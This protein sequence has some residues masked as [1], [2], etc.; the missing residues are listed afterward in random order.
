MKNKLT[1]LVTSLL[2]L[3]VLPVIMAAGIGEGIG[4]DIEVEPFKPIVW[5]C[6]HRYMQDDE[7][8]PWRFTNDDEFLYERAGNYLF[9]GEKFTVDVVVFDK[10]KIQDVV[11]DL[12][13]GESAGDMDYNVNCVERDNS[14]RDFYKC[15]A[16]I[17]EE[18]INEFDSAT[19]RGFTC[20]FTALDSEHMYGFHWLTVQADD[21]DDVGVYDEMTPLYLNPMI[22]LDVVGGLDFG[23]VRPGTSSYSQVLVENLAEGGVLLDMF[24]TGKDWQ[25]VDTDMGRCLDPNTGLLENYLS[26]GAFRYYTENGAWDSRSDAGVDSGYSSVTRNVDS[27]GYLNINKQ[28]NAGFEEAMFDDAE[29][30]QEGGPVVS[31]L[32][33]RANVLSPGSV[34]ALTFRLDLPEPCYGEFESSDDGSIFLWAEAI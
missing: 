15:N 18:E 3:S 16:R 17:G 31:G 33:Y 5:Q 4:G 27:E 2:V 32:G 19:M 22:E 12:I 6:D 24:I 30:I 21:G 14:A 23:I 28:L 10:N 26:L 25:A 20:T 11:V 13:L 1:L 29:L 34:M 7:V 9:E 8:Q